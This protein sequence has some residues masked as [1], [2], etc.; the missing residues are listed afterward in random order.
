MTPLQEFLFANH[1]RQVDLCEYLGTSASMVS[2][3]VNG[4]EKLYRKHLDKILSNDEGWDTT[5]LGGRPAPKVAYKDA[6]KREN[7]LLRS[8]LEEKERTIQILLDK[9]VQE[10]QS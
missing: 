9:W 2:K 4:R 1:L 6:L 8:L 7:E 5:M 3:M 10:K